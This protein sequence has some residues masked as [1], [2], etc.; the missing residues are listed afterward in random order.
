MR[1]SG[2]DPESSTHVKSSVTIDRNNSSVNMRKYHLYEKGSDYNQ[3][4]FAIRKACLSTSTFLIF[5]DF[6]R[7]SREN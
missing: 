5:S 7:I 6:F 3:M 4:Y 1:H 2:L